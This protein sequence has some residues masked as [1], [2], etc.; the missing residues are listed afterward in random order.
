MIR[1]CK[2][3][4]NYGPVR[5]RLQYISQKTQSD[6]KIDLTIVFLGYPKNPKISFLSGFES[7]LKLQSAL[8]MLKRIKMQ[9]FGYRGG[10]LTSVNYADIKI[11]AQCCV[12]VKI[13]KET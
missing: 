8:E 7:K 4:P 9:C 1:N 3:Q 6:A 12:E 2:N 13:S 11:M 10:L 5:R